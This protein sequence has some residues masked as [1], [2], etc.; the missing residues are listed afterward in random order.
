MIINLRV[1]FNR[2]HFNLTF[3]YS[4]FL[5]RPFRKFSAKHVSVFN[6]IKILGNLKFL[7]E[8]SSREVIF[9]LDIRTEGEN[10]VCPTICVRNKIFYVL[11]WIKTGKQW[12]T[13]INLK[14]K[15]KKKKEKTHCV[16]ELWVIFS[17]FFKTFVIISVNFKQLLQ[18]AYFGSSFIL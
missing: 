6:V 14:K 1:Y 15:K 13:N 2:T 5:V 8:F 17:I 4:L 12:N 3:K 16:D 7:V 18:F 11:F 10:I 9:V